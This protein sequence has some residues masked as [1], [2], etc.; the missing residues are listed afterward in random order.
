[1]IKFI[2]DLKWGLE[3]RFFSLE[4]SIWIDGETIY[5]LLSNSFSFLIWIYL[6]LSIS[7]FIFCLDICLDSLISSFMSCP[8]I[9]LVFSFLHSFS[10]QIFSLL[11][12][13][14]A[15]F[16]NHRYLLAKLIKYLSK[17]GQFKNFGA[18]NKQSTGNLVD[19]FWEPFLKSVTMFATG[20]KFTHPL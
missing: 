11:F 7:S 12:L 19:P 9:C 1:M 14:F 13:F 17:F 6:D 5:C 3:K 2:L 15:Q 4:F 10:V 20:V 16:Q 18:S 8:D